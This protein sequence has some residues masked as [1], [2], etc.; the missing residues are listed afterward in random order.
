MSK[1]DDLRRKES[2]PVT[3]ELSI[4]RDAYAFIGMLSVRHGKTVS[5]VVGALAYFEEAVDEHF[6]IYGHGQALFDRC[7]ELMEEAESKRLELGP[8]PKSPGPRM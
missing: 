1:K 5:E 6:G 3:V 2:Q 7:I 4:P 8:Q